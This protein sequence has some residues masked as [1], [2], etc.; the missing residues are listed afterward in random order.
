MLLITFAISQLVI[1][2]QSLVKLAK[3]AQTHKSVDFISSLSRRFH[4]LLVGVDMQFMEGFRDL[5]KDSISDY[6]FHIVDDANFAKMAYLDL[7]S[8]QVLDVT[9]PSLFLKMYS[10]TTLSKHYPLHLLPFIRPF[11]SNGNFIILTKDP[12]LFNFNSNTFELSTLNE[13]EQFIDRSNVLMALVMRNTKKGVFNLPV[14]ILD[15]DDTFCGIDESNNYYAR[16][17]TREFII[18]A[19]KQFD[20]Y[21]V[22]LSYAFSV[23]HKLSALGLANLINVDHIVGRD[24]LSCLTYY[25]ILHYTDVNNCLIEPTSFYVNYL[26]EAKGLVTDYTDLDQWGTFFRGLNINYKPLQVIPQIES[27]VLLNQFAIVDDQTRVYHNNYL[28]KIY[29]LRMMKDVK[30]D[31]TFTRLLASD[32]KELHDLV[33]K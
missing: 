24:T 23:Q 25:H 1:L 7:Y 19:Q 33:N 17:H 31:D 12:E 26:E 29:N 5:I 16:T 2:H 32:L 9:N 15:V 6:S 21:L 20:V 28:Q 18:A 4:V 11:L 8:T 27:R 14:L 30:N 13:F 10:Y 3:E 22:S